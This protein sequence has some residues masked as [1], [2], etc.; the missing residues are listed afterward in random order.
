MKAGWWVETTAA[1]SAVWKVARKAVRT[2]VWKV[3]RKAVKRAAR[4]VAM[5]VVLEPVL[6][7]QLARDTKTDCK[8]IAFLCR[9]LQENHKKE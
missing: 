5:S 3:A 9:R 7:R 6:V 1:R 4:R 2:A 8:D